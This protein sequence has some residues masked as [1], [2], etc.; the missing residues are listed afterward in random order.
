MSLPP[1]PLRGVS[2]A[3]QLSPSPLTRQNPYPVPGADRGAGT[4]EFPTMNRGGSRPR[5]FHGVSNGFT[6]ATESRKI[7]GA[8]PNRSYIFI[9]NNS[10]AS[11]YVNL[12]TDASPTALFM[13]L[14]ATGGFWEPLIPPDN[15]IYIYGVGSGFYIVG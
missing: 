3:A 8:D 7:I 6:L 10:A 1:Y 11:M 14:P 12:D 2:P 15:E 9:V 5:N 4:A 13:I